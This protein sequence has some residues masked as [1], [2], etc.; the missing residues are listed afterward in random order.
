MAENH[1][2]IQSKNITKPNDNKNLVLPEKGDLTHILSKNHA[3]QHPTMRGFDPRFADIIDY[4]V[5]ITHEIWEE[6]GIG[7][8]YEYYVLVSG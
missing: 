5:K 6:R 7:L 3:T 8:L 4:I 2:A 1:Q